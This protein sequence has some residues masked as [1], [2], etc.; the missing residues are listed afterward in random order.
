MIRGMFGFAAAAVTAFVLA[1]S[2][3]RAVSIERIVTPAGIEAWLVQNKNGPLIAMSYAFDGGASQDIAAKSG[4]ASLASNMLDEGAGDLD[5]NTYHERLESHAIELNFQVGRDYFHGSL[6]TLTEHSQEAFDLLH[7]ALAS[8]RFDA[9]ALERVRAQVMSNLRRETTSPNSLASNRWWQTAFPDHPYG[10][11]TSGT[12]ETVP[13]ITADDLRD[14]THRVFARN[15]LKVAIVGDVDAKTAG[16]LIDR[17]FGSLPAN[18]DL[19]PV[20]NVSPQGLGKTLVTDLDVPQAVVAFGGPGL[21]RDD[22]DFM[23]GYIVN[24][25]LGGGSFSSRL[26]REVREKRGL[27]YGVSDSLVWFRNTAVLIGGTATRADRTG[28][29]LTVIEN[30]TKRMAQDGPTAQELADAKSYL[31]G[32]YALGLDT[33][34]KVAAQL[35]Q[36]QLDHLGMD[37]IERRSGLIDAV[38]LDDAK[39]AAKRLYGAGMLVSVAGRPKGVTATE[40]LPPRPAWPGENAYNPPRRIRCRSFNPST[41]RARSASERMALRRARSRTRS[42]APKTRWIGCA[43]GT[44]MA[45]CRCCVTRK[46]PTTSARSVTRPRRW[47]PA[48]ATSS[49]SAPAAPASAARRWRN[50]PVTRSPARRSCRRASISW[51]IST[52]RRSTRCWRNYRSRRRALPRSRSRGAPARR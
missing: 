10:R 49:F 19:R 52:R 33:S 47:H 50:W 43:R 23:A 21:A 27:A 28:D 5:S 37:Y 2:P 11:D 22:K 14:F 20:A 4:A 13:T 40:S 34:S 9:V 38:T 48:P 29:A 45:A 8:P 6:R 30:E 1:A 36:I 39:R 15:G 32:A 26:Y 44:P 7:I 46:K 18:N 16:A 42:S 12:L 17:A 51:T 35:V 31:K 25:I 41:W 3:A 24:H